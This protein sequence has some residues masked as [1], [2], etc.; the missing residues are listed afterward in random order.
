MY[1]VN[2]RK[3]KLTILF[4]KQSFA[5]LTSYINAQTDYL[6]YGSDMKKIYAFTNIKNHAGNDTQRLSLTFI[7]VATPKNINS[8]R[9]PAE[10]NKMR[11]NFKPTSKPTAPNNSKTAVSVPAFS[12]PK[13][14]N[15][16]FICDDLKY[17]IP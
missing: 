16:F 15:S 7:L 9:P 1:N 5:K 11:R 3:N 10:I 13:R 8:A 12:S 14:L 6:V 17:A 4:Y 2:M